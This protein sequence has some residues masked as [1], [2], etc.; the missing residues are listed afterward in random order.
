MCVVHNRI[1]TINESIAHIEKDLITICF[2]EE[3]CETEH[4]LAWWRPG[5]SFPADNL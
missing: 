3:L 1:L 2:H 5:S 4:P